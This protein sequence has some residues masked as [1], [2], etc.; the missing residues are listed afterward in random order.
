ML[1]IQL[2][3]LAADHPRTHSDLLTRTHAS[4][5]RILTGPRGGR[6]GSTS[7]SE[8]QSEGHLAPSARSESR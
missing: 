8:T 7:R 2:E 5:A 1:F 6:L 4:S 3:V